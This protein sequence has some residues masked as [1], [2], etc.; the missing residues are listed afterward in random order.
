MSKSIVV[1]AVVLVAIA[2]GVAYLTRESTDLPGATTPAAAD[3]K[4][5][6][7][8]APGVAHEAAPAPQPL[9]PL[10][11]PLQVSPDNRLIKFIVGENGKVIAEIDQDPGSASFGKPMREYLYY[12]DKVVGLT[13]YRY[14]GD[15]V[16][17]TRTAVS[18]KPDGSVDAV[19]ELAKEIK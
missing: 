11:A 17:V 9:D 10:L 19:W 13:A 4:T 16:E 5:A 18:Y 7:G 15:R 8:Q 14:A 3:K 1:G 6:A 2:V 12:G